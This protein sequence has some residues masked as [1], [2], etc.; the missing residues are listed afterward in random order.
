MDEFVD[1]HQANL[2]GEAQTDEGLDDIV[3]FIY[4]EKV[5]NQ[6]LIPLA[7]SV[8][9]TLDL[10]HNKFKS[11]GGII[12]KLDKYFPQ[13][14][15]LQ[16]VKKVSFEEWFGKLRPK[17]DMDRMIDGAT[18]LPF[19]EARLRDVMHNVYQDI[20]TDGRHS[21]RERLKEGKVTFG[22]GSEIS[23]RRAN[24]RFI[25]FKTA[26][27][28]LNYDKEFG[29]GGNIADV[30]FGHINSMSRDIGLLEKMGPR[31]RAMYRRLQTQMGAENVSFLKQDWTDG[32]FRVMDGKANLGSDTPW[33]RA[34]G[35]VQ[36]W[37][38]SALLGSASISAISDVTF[39]GA[40]ARLNG[41]S[42]TKTMRRYFKFLNPASAKDRILAKR[43]GYTAEVLSSSMASDARFAGETISGKATNFLDRFA[44]KA[45]QFTNRASGLQAMTKAAAD[46]VSLEFQAV[47]AEAL[48]TKSFNRINP[49]LR[50]GLEGFGIGQKEWDI[51]QQ[52]KIFTDPGSGSKFLRPEDVALIPGVDSK[53]AL[54][55]SSRLDDMISHMRNMATNNP[56]LRT[57]SIQT[58]FGQ[59][60]DSLMRGMFSSPLMFKSF[61]LTVFFNHVIPSVQRASK[62]QWEHLA[63][64]MVG[65]TILGAM[66]LQ[67][68]E[69]TK[70]RTPKDWD[71]PK[72]ILAAMLQGGGLGLFG[73]FF[74]ADYSRFG[75]SP[76]TE[77]VGPIAGLA[78]DIL[79]ATKGNFDRIAQ[80]KDV[81][82]MRDMFRTMKRNIPGVSLW[83]SRLILERM[84]LD[85][86]E[87]MADPKFDQRTRKFERRI[88]K[89]FG[90]QY[91]WRKGNVAPTSSPLG[92]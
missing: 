82:F 5:I 25:H 60:R 40:T 89:D 74:L 86:M 39:I 72:F 46:A 84:L 14:H 9:D 76:I 69:I 53:T 75:R 48:P 6:D 52:S 19:E 32:M 91:W 57:R 20:V 50:E 81:N 77:A 90:Q 83:Y 67:A 41:L 13:R 22:K 27:D 30:I 11:A 62:G 66:A 2:L 42:A 56:D 73:D 70:G 68:K 17:L 85:H 33:V 36:N 47:L 1:K 24:H 15:N 87:R 58:A 10:A 44:Q 92:G 61:P 88:R 45:A 51:M 78:D 12:G 29:S 63:S 8:K 80:G 43:L 21:L 26:K 55:L 7:R 64:V 3:R 31:P 35:T 16:L 4:G 49:A 65:T 59:R 79:R 38:R 71:D 18:G 34:L 28:F 37:L 54:E 23:E